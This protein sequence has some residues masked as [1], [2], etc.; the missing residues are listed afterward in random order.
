M[1]RVLDRIGRAV[2]RVPGVTLVTLTA[3]TVLFGASVSLLEVDT[4]VDSFAP[5][6]GRAQ[7]LEQIDERFA[8][9][10]SV[11]ALIDAGPGG[12]VITPTIL[13][14]V[15]QLADDLEAHPD[16]APVLAA[17]GIDQP[18]VI[19]FALPFSGLDDTLDGALRDLDDTTFS[20]LATTLF[21]EGGEEVRPLFS[22]DLH[23]DP[24]RARA[25]LLVV[26][27]DAGARS[28][29]RA[30][31]TE[32]IDELV[33]DAD[34][35]GTR[36]GTLSALAI[37]HGIENALAR[38][39]PVLLSV[40]LLLMVIALI[41]LYRT[42]VDVAVGMLGLMAS[43]VWM[44]GIAALLGPGGLNL[45]G[46]FNQ[47]TI[48][49]P[50]IL[51]G[52]GIDYS[53]HLTT[54]Y[55]EQRR[56]GD[57]PSR[58]SRVALA[59]VGI[60]L[61]LA[62]LT[63]VA[64]FLSN[65]V[66]PLP[67]I[68]DFGIFAAIGIISAFVILS[69]AVPAARTLV[70]H[71]RD[72]RR[73]P[74]AL[75]RAPTGT[76]LADSHNPATAPTCGAGPQRPA[77]WVRATSAVAIRYP[78]GA[79]AATVVVL[80]IA[81]IAASGLSTEFDERDFLPQGAPVLATIDRIETQ[82]GGDLSE[83]TFLLVDGDPWDPAVA[84]AVGA[85]E[86]QLTDVEDVRVTAGRAE[87]TSPI[88]LRERI[89]MSG[90]RTRSMIADELSTWRDPEA[91]AQAVPLPA[92]ID[93]DAILGD[94]DDRDLEMLELG[95]RMPGD[96][97]TGDQDA[98]LLDALT[99]RLPSGREPLAA[100]LATGDPAMIDT[101]IRA[102][103][104]DGFRAE[105]PVGLDDATLTDLVQ[106]DEAALTVDRLT[107]AGYQLDEAQRTS[108]NRLEALEA[109]GEVGSLEGA[110]L[111][112]HLEV[113]AAHAPDDLAAVLDDQGLIVTI[114]T[115]ASQDG[116]SSL[117]RSLTELAAPIEDAGGQIEVVSTPLVTTEIIDSL[118]SAQLVAIAISLAAVGLLLALAT[119]LSSRTFGLGLIGIV[120]SV[121]GLVLVLGAMRGLGLAFNALTA[122]VASISVGI[123]VPYGIHVTNRF[124][125][126]LER[127]L[128]PDGAASNLLINT[129]PALIGSAV[130]TGLAFVVL[131]L[132]N[133]V[134]VQQF[135]LVSTLMIGFALL[136]CLLVQPALL[137]L[138]A[139]RRIIVG[140]RRTGRRSALHARA[141]SAAGAD[142][143]QHHGQA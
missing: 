4:G 13:S 23:V 32:I 40:S 37:E 51:V 88:S 114:G 116:A 98:A 130:T 111:V 101:L 81:G 125:E 31:A 76:T 67:P 17:T 138:W 87:R 39:L 89:V 75:G 77:W 35:D 96:S 129:G 109:A 59:T 140:E 71:R 42:V 16:V 106:R 1:T 131:T 84:A 24:P 104:A 14:Q 78:G 112:A 36:R 94:I 60:S 27:L 15:Q 97:V 142:P 56:A 108:L 127:G 82:F 117:A 69:T 20:M 3:L 8:T 30:A 45:I 29:A 64:G 80:G 22:D 55:R 52:L 83:Q 10:T 74:E 110:T 115:N 92:T 139:R 6:G 121:V 120:P 19:S 100:L 41:V 38:D 135:G 128:G 95:D 2:T 54:R 90:Q 141:G 63:S 134:P 122:T 136:A 58:A 57:D 85:V 93:A 44:A 47:I 50:V 73:P 34:I 49:V 7:T 99:D 11:Q 5:S 126:N 103:L 72:A 105:R 133:S 53:V 107:Q 65:L 18:P 124:R 86:A 48:A 12:N 118:S 68:Q 9:T 113:L 143:Y 61:V 79:L 21:A 70:D 137:V 33:T 25:G 43:I 66:T 91:A 119:V 46:P 123:G 26:A 132:S 28:D 62:T 102:S